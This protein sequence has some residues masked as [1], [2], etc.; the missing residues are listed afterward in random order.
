MKGFIINLFSHN[1]INAINII[2]P[3][4]TYPYII[5]H[6]GLSN[7]GESVFLIGY[8]SV[9][10]V[11]CEYA[12]NLTGTK[13]L[14]RVRNTNERDMIIS[15][16]ITSKL[17]IYIFITPIA[18]FSLIGLGKGSFLLIFIGAIIPFSEVINT[19]WVFIVNNKTKTAAIIVAL[20]RFITIPLLY[21]F[22]KD[23][24]DLTAYMLIYLFVVLSIP[25]LQII[26]LIFVNDV[27][28][29]IL[30]KKHALNALRRG[31]AL[32]IGRVFS[33]LKDRYI[34]IWLG[35]FSSHEVIAIYDILNKIVSLL[36]N[37]IYSFSMVLFPKL[38]GRVK[39]YINFNKLIFFGTITVIFL[40]TIVS[41]FSHLIL[42]YFGSDRLTPYKFELDMFLLAM[43]LLY[44]SSLIGSCYLVVNSQYKTYNFSIILSFGFI[45]ISTNLLYVFNQLDIY[46][47][48]CIFLF[49]SFLEAIVRLYKYLKVE[50][51]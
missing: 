7:Y 27:K 13:K 19:T 10:I 12:F 18:F 45:V 34:A 49:S 16:V 5:N 9:V 15:Q 43:P 38:S 41:S 32:F 20:C 47:L 17:Y 23:T 21:F 24:D 1:I 44:I 2:V 46:F 22:V 48:A 28:I 50:I 35:F 11:F 6:L 4:I 3:L 33:S 25:I 37:P 39:G 26:Y 36:M 8:F 30:P 14:S 31:R 29:R 42:S 40:V 51:K